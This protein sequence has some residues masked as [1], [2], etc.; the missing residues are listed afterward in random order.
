MF[1]LNKS[2]FFTAGVV[3]QSTM[4][5]EESCNCCSLCALYCNY[6]YLPVKLF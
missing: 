5:V 1:F 2:L 3:L 4:G 6:P